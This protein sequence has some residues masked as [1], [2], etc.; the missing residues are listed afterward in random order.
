[1]IFKRDA[2]QAVG[3]H[4]ALGTNF[5]DDIVLARRIKAAKLRWRV[6]SIADLVSCRM[7]RSSQRAYQGLDQEP[8]WCLWLPPFVLPVCH[9][10]A[11]LHDLGADCGLCPLAGR[12]GTPGEPALF[13]WLCLGFGFAHLADRLH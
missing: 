6:L 13:C 7:Y 8:V 3:G 9:L 1:M 4:A 12:S 10:V 5:L 2:Y 11:C